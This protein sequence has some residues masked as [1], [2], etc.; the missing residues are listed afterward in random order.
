MKT[1]LVRAGQI[2]L[3]VAVTWLIVDL[4]DLDLAELRGMETSAW[5]PDLVPLAAEGGKLP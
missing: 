5:V 3:T 4:V 2:A 1:W